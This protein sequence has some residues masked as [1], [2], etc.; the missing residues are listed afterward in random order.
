M[1]ILMD[2]D[3]EI[4]QELSDNEYIIRD[5]TSEVVPRSLWTWICR[6]ALDGIRLSDNATNGDIIKTIFPD[7][8]VV[9]NHNKYEINNGI[10]E[11]ASYI[12]VRFGHTEVEFNAV[13]WG[14][15][16]KREN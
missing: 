5:L 7:C 1:K 8:R 9:G 16:Y 6:Y 4:Y 12:I 2:V 15:L 11:T 3:K 10:N 13:W 14:S